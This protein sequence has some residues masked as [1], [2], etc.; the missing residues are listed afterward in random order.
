MVLRRINNLIIIF[1]IF[2]STGFYELSMLGPLQKIAEL[3]GIGLI[4]LLLSFHIVYA[5]QKQFPHNFTLPIVFIFIS[6]L[7]ST[8]MAKYSRDQSFGETLYSARSLF[9][10]LFY[11]LLHQL[12]I[13]PKDLET[14]LFAL[15]I[16]YVVLFLLQYLAYPTKIFNTYVRLDRGTIRIYL[17]GSAYL[18]VAFL[19]SLQFFYRTNKIKYMIL[20][21]VFLSIFVLTGGRQTL[22]IMILVLTLFLIF[23]R[24]VKSRVMLALLGITGSFM[25]FLIF[26]NIFTALIL[27]TQ[28]DVSTGQDYI[29]VQAA[30][31]FLTDF[32]K[33]AMSYITG[34]GMHAGVSAYGTEITGY[35]VNYGYFLG[36][37]GII[38]NYAIYG[39]FF[40]IGIILFFIR[41]FKIRIEQ[42]YSYIKYLFIV[43]LISI[44]TGSAFTQSHFICCILCL[45][46]L[47]DLSNYN[48][49]T[50]KQ[51]DYISKT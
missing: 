43:A 15:G 32:F 25:I 27:K 16:I 1:I 18:S 46:Y 34:N 47:I 17:A 51:S 28:T 24:K 41:A 9:Y 3:L 5:G 45:F 22:A 33:N 2:C 11:F 4:I 35:K 21:L 6:L 30:I 40:L 23:D 37:I 50:N 19:M 26:R 29:R 31:F 10:Y 7:T 48:L 38:G 49:N 20:L 12:K 42:Q 8:I 14:I 13:R 44:L 39:I 36:D